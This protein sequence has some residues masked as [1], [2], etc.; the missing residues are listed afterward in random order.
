MPEIKRIIAKVR[1]LWKQKWK[2]L[3]VRYV[4]RYAPAPGEKGHD[5]ARVVDYMECGKYT[6]MYCMLAHT[7]AWLDILEV[8]G[9]NYIIH[10]KRTEDTDQ[11][12]QKVHSFLDKAIELGKAQNGKVKHISFNDW[13]TPGFMDMFSTKTNEYKRQTE[14][15]DLGD[16]D[17][18]GREI[19]CWLSSW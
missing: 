19:W 9:E 14:E 3:R 4:Y 18:E 16:L 10:H 11:A 7:Q 1:T 5:P 6:V 2:N 15:D 12:Q 13:D 17:E 8:S